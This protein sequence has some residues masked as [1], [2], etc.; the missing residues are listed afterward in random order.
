LDIP[1]YRELIGASENAILNLDN[2]IF[3]VIGKSGAGKTSYCKTF[4]D[5][6]LKKDRTAI[7]LSS[8]LTIKQYNS[9]FNN[10]T[11]SNNSRTFFINP[12]LQIS[13]FDDNHLENN[14][15]DAIIKNI[16]K[17]ISANIK[18]NIQENNFNK[19]SQQNI[20]FVF[21][22]LSHLFNIFDEKDVLRF[23]NSLYFILKKYNILSIFTIDDTIINKSI[24]NKISPLFDGIL[25]IKV[26]EKEDGEVDRSI[27]FVSIIGNPSSSFKSKKFKID[28][29]YSLTFE[30]PV[31]LICSVCKEVIQKNPSFHLDMAFHQNHLELYKKLMG[32]YGPI[33]ISELG[34]SVVMTSTFFFIDI[35]G[36]S[37]PILSVRKQIEKIEVL[38]NFILACDAFKKNY[39]RK[40]LPTGDGMAIGFTFNPE[41]PIELGIQLH[42]KLNEYN[43]NK[44]DESSI[45]TRIGIASGPVFIVNDIN[46]NQNIWGPG[47]IFA[48]RIMDIGDD[49]HILIDGSLAESLII[50][51]DKYNDILHYIGDYPI[52]HGQLI[53]LYS[54]YDGKNFGN[55]NIPK[56]YKSLALQ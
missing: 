30:N 16:Q 27:K 4:F 23:V 41:A 47:I 8:T 20:G 44:N 25:K 7:Y 55:R 5:S 6:C 49:K 54:A 11:N 51:D 56:K 12:F 40:I 28:N 33:R 46:N 1:G 34:P 2:A 35:V 9:I 31:S 42:I 24:L 17:I 18:S 32:I 29:N 21:D 48:R 14:V 52:K 45:D 37:S 10:I 19:I 13:N 22:S 38:N 50:L 53:R 3:L 36:L 43:E 39:E 26:E 15:L